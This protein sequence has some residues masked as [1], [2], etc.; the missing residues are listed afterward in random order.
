MLFYQLA[1]PLLEGLIGILLQGMA[2]IKEKLTAKTTAI[3]LQIV[4][5][6]DEYES[7]ASKNNSTAIGFVV[8]KEEEEYNEEDF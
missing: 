4:K 8:N 2:V 7:L 1:L 3:S 5:M 6:Q